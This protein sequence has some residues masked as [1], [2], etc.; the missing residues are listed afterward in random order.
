MDLLT[1]ISD[2]ERKRALAR[3]TSSSEGYLWQ[4]ATGWRGKRPSP[5]LALAIEAAT[6][7]IGPL[8]VAK[9]SLRPD[10]WSAPFSVSEVVLPARRGKE[11]HRNRVASAEANVEAAH[12]REEEGQGGNVHAADA[13]SQARPAA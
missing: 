11:E 10:L 5:E 8:P 4:C 12:G 1:F 3:K 6:A 2:R 9:E 13:A 7:E